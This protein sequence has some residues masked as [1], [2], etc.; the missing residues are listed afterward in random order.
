MLTLFGNSCNE[1]KK[2]NC[3]GFLQ[4]LNRF[5]QPV[6]AERVTGSVVKMFLYNALV[7]TENRHDWSEEQMLGR[8]VASRAELEKSKRSGLG[9]ISD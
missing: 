3:H 2:L 6:F 8:T 5:F 4:K 9:Y 1:E 7:L